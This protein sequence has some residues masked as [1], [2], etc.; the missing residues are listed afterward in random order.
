MSTFIFIANPHVF[1]ND[2]KRL[3][4][5]S[6]IINVGIEFAVYIVKR[7]R[8]REGQEESKTRVILSS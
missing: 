1:L 2:F 3:K 6:Q 8:S 7:E 5:F 4:L